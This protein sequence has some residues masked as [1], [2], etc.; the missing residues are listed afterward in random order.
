ML[1]TWICYNCS[2]SSTT[3]IFCCFKS[4]QIWAYLLMRFATLRVKKLLHYKFDHHSSYT[5]P[6]FVNVCL[7]IECQWFCLHSVYRSELNKA[8]EYYRL[9]PSYAGSLTVW[10]GDRQISSWTFPSDCNLEQQSSRE[11]TALASISA[12]TCSPSK[13][14]ADY[15][16]V[17][18]CG[19]MRNYL[20]G[21]KQ[22]VICSLLV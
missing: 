6:W 13:I 9:H 16:V 18:L 8:A 1:H 22:H 15:I 19:S 2:W 12:D 21:L 14:R 10:S 17:K 7:V 11:C 3:I 20:K 4:W 5:I